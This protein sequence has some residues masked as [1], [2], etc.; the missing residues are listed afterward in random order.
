MGTIKKKIDGNDL[1]LFN[2]EGKSWA[3]A[4]NHS[5]TFS[6]DTLE[7]LSK[8]C[9]KYPFV[10]RGKMS[11]EITSE[12][13]FCEDFDDLFEIMMAK[14]PITLKFGIKKNEGDKYVSE[15]DL[16]SWEIDGYQDYFTGKFIIVSLEASASTGEK[17]TYSVNFQSVGK[18]KQENDY[19]K[20]DTLTKTQM[21]LKED[22]HGVDYQLY[23][24]YSHA[25][26][27]FSSTASVRLGDNHA[28]IASVN[29]T[30]DTYFTVH[31]TP[32]DDY[33]T[34]AYIKVDYDI[35]DGIN[36]VKMSQKIQNNGQIDILAPGLIYNVIVE[37][38]TIYYTYNPPTVISFNSLNAEAITNTA[39]NQTYFVWW[40]GLEGRSTSIVLN[41]TTQYAPRWTYDETDKSLTIRDSS[42]NVRLTF[43]STWR[44]PS[45]DAQTFDI[46]YYDIEND[47][48]VEDTYQTGQ[49]I[50]F[51]SHHIK[52]Y[53]V[54]MY[55]KIPNN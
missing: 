48:D 34:L 10:E 46:N 45:V 20:I 53:N 19:L 40:Y 23:G 24:A 27:R 30:Q 37:N 13:L 50:N 47:Y 36:H 29:N 25:Y 16:A 38:V 26:V 4:T 12:N 55:Y 35:W 3:W 51:Q 33:S 6:I 14:T 42:D 54:I 31:A 2:T 8:D 1:M 41:Q 7:I 44:S 9:P 11:V 17:A 18:I 5:L 39:P 22:D 32:V 28:T 15:G 21:W 52:I 43:T 49:L